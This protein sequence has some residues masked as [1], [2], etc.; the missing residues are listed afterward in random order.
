MKKKNKKNLLSGHK[1]VKCSLLYSLTYLPSLV[2]FF[3][4]LDWFDSCIDFVFLPEE[5]S[6]VVHSIGLSVK[7]SPRFCLYGCFYF[8]LLFE[9]SFCGVWSYEVSFH[10]FTCVIL[11][12]FFFCP[13]CSACGI[14]V[15]TRDWT[16]ARAVKAQILST[17]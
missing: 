4:L 5:H 10:H 8:T 15:P 11:F 16:R 1:T 7:N 14:S 17:N 6:L 2:S 12:F 3:L 9:G 13:W